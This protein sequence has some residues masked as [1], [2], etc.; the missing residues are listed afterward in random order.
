MTRT[1]CLAVFTAFLL[2][3]PGFSQTKGSSQTQNPK[4]PT[5]NPPDETLPPEEDES[6]APEKFVL[7]PLESDRNIRVGNFYWHKAD[8]H[9]ALARYER[10]SKYNPNS[11][12]AFFKI[13]EAEERLK[14][15]DAAK[16]A[17]QRVIQI[18]PDSK[19]AHDAE[20]KLEKK[21]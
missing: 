6:V 10:A 18:A 8:Y 11:P 20:K 19:F 3:Q 7:N 9:A 5:Q 15:Q 16:I 4:Q 14:N 12:E 2:T 17:F 13:G 1:L 21:H